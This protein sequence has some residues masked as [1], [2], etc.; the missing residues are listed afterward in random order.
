MTQRKKILVVGGGGREHALAW[1]LAH[2]SSRPEVFCAPGN[3]GTASVGTNLDIAATDIP[4]LL[5][6]AKQ[7]RPALTVV[8]PEAPLCEGISDLF[9]AEG[10]K[11]F[12]PSRAAAQ[13]EGSK[14]F[15]KDV[16]QAAG[17]PTAAYERFEDVGAAKAYIRKCGAPIVVK[18]DG[19]AAGKGVTVAATVEQAEAAV[20]EALVQKAFGDAGCSVV[21][22]ECLVGEEASILALI[23]GERIVMLASSQ[24]HKRVFDRD[25]G[26]NTGGMGAYSPAPVVTDDL[27]PV[28]REQVFERTLAELK[29]RGITFRGVLYA[30]LMMTAGGPKVLEF[31]CRF[32]DPETEAILPRWKGDLLPAL[33]AC[34]DGRLEERLVQWKSEACVC[35]V[36]A[37]GGYPGSYSKGDVIE[38]LDIAGAMKD[39]VVF[40]A[41]TK[42][43]DGHVVTAGGRVLGVTALG[44]DLGSAVKRAYEACGSIQFGRAHYRKDIAARAFARR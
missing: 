41:G 18:A 31:N 9:A 27:W 10:F 33:E 3:A 20:D 22:E 37:A 35:V 8:G 34:A 25:E 32:G 26:P 43:K 28:I 19:L 21:V 24:D 11:V 7:H 13:L 40:H 15:A 23:D 16:M 4:K 38:G 39:V 2:D 6:W 29:R 42:L 17:V 30:G 44:A 12:G 36:M 1:K 5:A 14:A